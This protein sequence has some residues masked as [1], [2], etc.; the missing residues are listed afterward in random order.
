MKSSGISEVRVKKPSDNRPARGKGQLTRVQQRR[1]S[2]NLTSSQ[3]ARNLGTRVP[4]ALAQAVEAAA[5]ARKMS[6][7]EFL[8][9]L[10]VDELDR[11]SKPSTTKIEAAQQQA[12]AQPATGREAL[13][14]VKQLR[15]EVKNGLFKIHKENEQLIGLAQKINRVLSGA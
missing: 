11:Q 7:S 6:V 2:I 13:Q 4:E 12:Q 14:E 3:N 10:I 15:E 9:T 8:R 1:R 5:E